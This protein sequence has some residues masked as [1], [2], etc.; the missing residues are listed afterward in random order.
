[1]FLIFLRLKEDWPDCWDLDWIAAGYGVRD[2]YSRIIILKIT[3]CGGKIDFNINSEYRYICIFNCMFN[4][5][6]Y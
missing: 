2:C 5:N 1:M 6:I 3:K 4:R